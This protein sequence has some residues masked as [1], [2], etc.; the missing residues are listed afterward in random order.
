MRG[1]PKL[2]VALQ[3]EANQHGVHPD[4]GDDDPDR[5]GL[6][7]QRRLPASLHWGRTGVILRVALS[8]ALGHFGGKGLGRGRGLGAIMGCLGAA[9]PPGTTLAGVGPERVGP[10]PASLTKSATTTAVATGRTA[11]PVLMERRLPS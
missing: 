6:P 10:V 11:A 9:V 3:P 4:R 8:G 2:A 7:H 5:G 1:D